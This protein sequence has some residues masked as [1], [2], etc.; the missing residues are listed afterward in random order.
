GCSAQLL[1]PVSDAEGEE[2]I[3]D[4]TQPQCAGGCDGE[5]SVTFTCSEPDCTIAWYDG[6][7]NDLGQS[8]NVVA[9]LCA[10]TYVVEVTNGQGCISIATVEVVDP[11][12]IQPNSS[13]TPASCFGACD[14]TATVGPTG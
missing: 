14:G 8:G 3:T 5:V 13:S 1:V 9:G 7:G 2:L 11:P 6:Q 12:A 4:S 10:G